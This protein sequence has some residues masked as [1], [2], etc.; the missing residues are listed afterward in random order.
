MGRLFWKFFSFLWLAQML[1]AFG[2]GVAI[3]ALRPEKGACAP[4]PLIEGSWNALLHEWRLLGPPDGLLPPLLPIVAGSIASLI[5]AAVLAWYFAH[6]IRTL[7][8]AFA[9]VA[10]GDLSTRARGAMHGRRDEL[11]DLAGNFDEMAARLEQLLEGQRRLLHDVSHE[12]RSPLARMQVAVDLIEQQ[13][14]RLADFLAR[15]RRDNERTNRLVGELLTLARLDSDNAPPA[16]L[17]FDL[18]ELLGEIIEDAELE[19]AA[20]HCKIVFSHPASL[21]VQANPELLRRAVENVLRNALRHAPPASVV[22]VQVKENGP[23]CEILISDQGPGVAE[24]ELATMFAPFRRCADARANAGF[25][26]GLAITQRVMQRH[27]GQ[28]IAVNRGEGGLQVRLILPL[29]PVL[30]ADTVA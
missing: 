12:L 6:P 21:L 24:D 20:A 17:E 23:A 27:G 30:Q 28:V 5:F 14:E 22:D 19:A 13:P 10:G 2:V 9:A 29:H 11:A 25:G 18:L 4:P 26:L 16:M 7:R 15:L 8:Q 3:W 1:T